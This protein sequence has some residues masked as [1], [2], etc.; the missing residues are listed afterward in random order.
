M[1][2]TPK[3]Y[4]IYLKFKFNWYPIF[5]MAILYCLILYSVLGTIY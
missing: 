1:K 2:N 3:N 5:Y 4:V